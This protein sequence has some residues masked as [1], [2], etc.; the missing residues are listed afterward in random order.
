VSLPDDRPPAA[1]RAQDGTSAE[2]APATAGQGQEG[3]GAPPPRSTF[4]GDLRAVLSERDFRKLFATRLIAQ[5]GDGIFTAGLGTYVFFNNS[6]YPSP[7]SAAAAFAALYLPYSLVGPF[8]GVFI[9]RWSRRQILVWSAVIRAA[10][11]ALAAVLV[12]SGTLGGPLLGVALVVFG[13]NRFFLA[14]L[15]AALPHVVRP[16]KLVMANGVSPTAGGI[17]TIIGA[18]LALLVRLLTGGGHFG[19][20][21]IL[22]AAGCCYL[23]SGLPA[24][25]MRRDLLGPDLPAGRPAGVVARLTEVA[26]A[27]GSVATGLADGARHV[28]HRRQAAAALGATAGNKFC[29]GALSVLVILLYRNYFYPRSANAALG[30]FT[31]LVGIPLAVGFAA[32]AFVTP[33]ALRRMTK[34]AWIT[35][36]LVACTVITGA[37][38]WAFTEV[39][40]VVIA[41]GVSL[42]G[43]DVA[44]AAVTILQEEVADSFR[45]RVFAFYDIAF[46]AALAAG[47]IVVAL[48][49]PASGKSYWVMAA[50]AVCYL[51]AAAGYR[52]AVR[53]PAGGSGT[54]SPSA[55]AQRSSS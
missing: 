11:V 54:S 42:A 16:D 14:S 28:W 5:T 55:S 18:G 31:T 47:A 40:F 25:P 50:I 30:H 17:M 32:A 35:A 12:G 24:L 48:F 34:Q 6:T 49:L 46:S 44:I 33:P 41:F 15:S 3:N 21:M 20:A 10:L 52:A 9:D 29:Y 39:A 27:L 7:G 22:V 26:G 8:A 36:G 1:I 38:G 2:P 43:Q 13:V 19:S 23:L 4:I 45:G 51:L 53:Q 37:L